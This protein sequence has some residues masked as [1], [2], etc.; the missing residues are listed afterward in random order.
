MEWFWARWYWCFIYVYGIIRLTIAQHGP[1]LYIVV[2]M[3]P[4]KS[5]FD[6]VQSQGENADVMDAFADVLGQCDSL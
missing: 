3:S 2:I 6:G 4:S 1:E 5:E